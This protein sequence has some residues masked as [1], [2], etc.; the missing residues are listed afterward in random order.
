MLYPLE[1]GIRWH[2]TKHVPWCQGNRCRHAHGNKEL[3]SFRPEVPWCPESQQINVFLK[4]LRL[5]FGPQI[6]DVD[7]WMCLD[8]LD[9]DVDG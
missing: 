2:P 1:I 8:Y 6:R 4:Y 9:L 5:F 7:G 3:R